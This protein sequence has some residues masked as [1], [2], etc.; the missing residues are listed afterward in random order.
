VTGEEHRHDNEERE[1]ETA[2]GLE[3]TVE[4]LEA[5]AA[6]LADIAGGWCQDRISKDA[7]CANPRT[8]GGTDTTHYPPP[9]LGRA[10]P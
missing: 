7:G 2:E 9:P 10:A 8:C 4:D 3:A 1:P 5:P 6:A